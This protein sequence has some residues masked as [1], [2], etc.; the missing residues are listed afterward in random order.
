[1]GMDVK[2]I[3]FLPS[4]PAPSVLHGV[5]STGGSVSLLVTDDR[6]GEKLHGVILSLTLCA[7]GLQC[8]ISL[9]HSQPGG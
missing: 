3:S 7:I 2:A 9:S 8:V 6:H 1:M 4:L 5:P